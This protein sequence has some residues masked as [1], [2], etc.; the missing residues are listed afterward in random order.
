MLHKT[1]FGDICTQPAVCPQAAQSQWQLIRG[2]SNRQLPLAVTIGELS[3]WQRVTVNLKSGFPA[4]IPPVTSS[5]QGASTSLILWQAD[6][7]NVGG[8]YY[9]YKFHAYIFCIFFAYFGIYMQL[10]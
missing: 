8:A 6:I 10:R 5:C 2:Q 1:I 7:S 4:F 9:A 3:H